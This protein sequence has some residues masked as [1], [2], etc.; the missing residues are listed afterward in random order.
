MMQ[1]RALTIVAA[2]LTVTLFAAPTRAQVTADDAAAA[3]VEAVTLCAKAKVAGGGI[4]DLAEAAGHV[5]PAGDG[6]R[7]FLRS[8][9][10]RPIWDVLSARGVV[11]ISE[12]D[13]VSCEVT[14]YGPRVRPV[15]DAAARELTRAELGF[16]EIDVQQD[17]SAIVRE[18][19]RVS[20]GV[21]VRLDGGEPGMPGRVFRFPML[22]AYVRAQ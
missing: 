2:A 18:F 16:S 17:P 19:T 12:P 14:A 21:N 4:G 7:A 1:A 10:G 15:F 22:L 5:A 8:P 11:L 9:E 3:F 20:P 13:D 6:A